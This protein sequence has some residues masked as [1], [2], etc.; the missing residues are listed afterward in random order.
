M[1]KN[2]DEDFKKEYEKYMDHV[3]KHFPVDLTHPNDA[4]TLKVMR[5]IAELFHDKVDRIYFTYGP[6][7]EVPEPIAENYV[8]QLTTKY[9]NIKY[10]N[11]ANAFQNPRIDLS[12][13]EYFFNLKHLNYEGARTVSQFWVEILSKD[14]SWHH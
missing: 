9:K 5:K 8:N 7:F 10:I 2:K 3:K 14:E 12:N 4:H 6:Q 11:S 13:K 1:N